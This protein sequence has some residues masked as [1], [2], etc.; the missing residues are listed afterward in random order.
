MLKRVFNFFSLY[1]GFSMV[2]E[3][4][5]SGSGGGWIRIAMRSPNSTSFGQYNGLV[6]YIADG[7]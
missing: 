2:L 1:T 6:K 5:V 7:K 3:N 4:D